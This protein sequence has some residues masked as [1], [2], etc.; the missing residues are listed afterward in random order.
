MPKFRKKKQQETHWNEDGDLVVLDRRVFRQVGWQIL[1]GPRNGVFLDM[2]P[3]KIDV[4]HGGL[5]PV[6]IEVGDD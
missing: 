5:A 4:P 2:D 6:Y 1:G 3:D